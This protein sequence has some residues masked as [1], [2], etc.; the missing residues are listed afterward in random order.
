MSAAAD[1]EHE[2]VTGEDFLEWLEPGRTAD[3]IVPLR[4]HDADPPADG[5]RLWSDALPRGRGSAPIGSWRF[6]MKRIAYL[7]VI[8]LRQKL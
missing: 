1:L 2:L 4:K 7:D 8:A 3:L 6:D 5:D